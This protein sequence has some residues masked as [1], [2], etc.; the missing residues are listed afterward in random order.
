[1]PADP[2]DLVRSLD[3][4]QG[5]YAIFGSGP[6]IVRGIVG[7]GND[8][9]LLS[10]GPAWTKARDAGTTVNLSEFDVEVVSLFDD[11]VTVGTRWA[12][13]EFDTD[14]LIDTA[15]R[16]DG[17]PFVRLEHVVR[18]K[19]LARRPKDLEHLRLLEAARAAGHA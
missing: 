4:P 17:L 15:E 5:H 9:D 11:V 6:L 10:R 13:G 12:I 1:V 7:A 19:R 8:L 2:F 3:L 14:E 16:I 18:Y